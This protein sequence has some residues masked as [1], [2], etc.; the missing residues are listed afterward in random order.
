MEYNKLVAVSGLP[1]L[2]E[3][4]SSKSDGAIVRSLDDQ[5]TKFA[6]SRKH[7]FSHLES[8]EIYTVA[9]NVNLAEVFQAMDAA[10]TELPDVKDD[11]AIKTYFGKVYSDMDF[12]RVYA[13]DM[14]KMVKWFDILKKNNIEIKLSEPV[15]EVDEVEETVETEEKPK[16]KKEAKAAAEEIA[17]TPVKEKSSEKKTAPKKTAAKKKAE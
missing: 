16:A 17:E 14:K 12:D 13:S 15:E 9:D 6:A 1:G 11:K 5:T 3:L 8:I 7:Q 10:G 4:I 2:F